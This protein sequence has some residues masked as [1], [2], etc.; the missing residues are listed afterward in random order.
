MS[1]RDDDGK[2]LVV[3]SFFDVMGMLWQAVDDLLL[4]QR[5]RRR[6]RAAWS[7]EIDEGLAQAVERCWGRDKRAALKLRVRRAAAD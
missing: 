7:V 4:R 3:L 1:Q 5:L 6:L 2:E